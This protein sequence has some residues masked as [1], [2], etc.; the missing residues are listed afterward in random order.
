MKELRHEVGGKKVV[1]EDYLLL[2]EQ[3][4]ESATAMLKDTSDCI[5]SGCVVTASAVLGKYDVSTGYVW[6]GGKILPVPAVIAIDMP[7][8]IVASEPVDELRTYYD[9]IARPVATTYAAV[10]Q[11]SGV[12]IVLSASE[13]LDFWAIL[14]YKINYADKA[15]QAQ[16]AALQA[17][18]DEL[19]GLT[20]WNFIR[21]MAGGGYNTDW[22]DDAEYD[23]SV[24]WRR[25]AVNKIAMCGV[26]VKSADNGNFKL[27]TL[28][29]NA[30]PSRTIVLP[31]NIY[32][33]D[34]RRTDENVPLLIKPNGDVQW[35]NTVPV[36]W[37][38]G[39]RVAFDS[40]EYFTD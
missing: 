8:V 30:R 33:S 9:A 37:A 1:A 5:L 22:S 11:A 32:I 34:Y 28:P 25:V 39:H 13:R 38:V 17:Q 14:K 23:S 18:I 4:R 3:A 6:L 35:A 7:S 19:N 27:F 16:V 10:I 40:V 20:A 24:G 29:I 31:S 15:T 12:G 21:D 26:A 36:T 2:D